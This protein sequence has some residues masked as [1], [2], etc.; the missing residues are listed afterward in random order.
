MTVDQGIIDKCKGR[1]VG[2]GPRALAVDVGGTKIKAGLV[3]EAGEI[4]DAE[5]L[6]TPVRESGSA[7][8]IIDTVV[9]LVQTFRERHGEDAVQ[10]VAMVVPGIIDDKNGVGVYSANLHFTDVPFR[11]LLEKR[12]N[13]PATVYHDV[14]GA[15]IAEFSL[16][17][18]NPKTAV[19]I[20][21][22]TG[23]AAAIRI[24]GHLYAGGGYAGEI[25]WS[26]VTVTTSEGIYHGPMERIASAAA[27]ARRYT[28]RTGRL[29]EGSAEVF[30]ARQNGDP[31]AAEV[32]DEAMEA[33]GSACAKMV[34][35]LAPDAIIF[36][37][38][39][40]SAV[41]L[42]EDVQKSLEKRLTFQRRPKLYRAK[43]GS[44]AGMLGAA[45]LTR[46]DVAEQAMSQ[47]FE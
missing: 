8:L 38:G 34:S 28:G 5:L 45:M 10:A 44:V 26:T 46:P 3:N 39:L 43:L 35:I 2:V 18:G 27:I 1:S 25:G 47:I 42:H 31:I 40:A 33:L 9:D 32:W 7:D 30:H 21:I 22:G 20:T 15:G 16:V 6:P 19:M 12:L 13:M 17:E 37:G 29:T 4:I 41:T 24:A 11:D 36:G 23:I 14:R